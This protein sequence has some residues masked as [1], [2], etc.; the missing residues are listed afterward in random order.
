MSKHKRRI[1]LIQPQ[2][3]LKLIGTFLGMSALSLLLQFLLFTSRVSE[4]AGTLPQDG[5]LLMSSLQKTT[6]QI[7]L[8]SFGMLLP[9][10]FLVGVLV[11]FRWA[12]PLYR[13][14][15]HLMRIANGERPGDVRIR[16]GDE[17]QDFCE[18]LNRAVRDLQENPAGNTT[19]DEDESIQRAA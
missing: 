9:L 2:L 6:W 10:T 15:V 7:F 17:L 1:K 12:G 11:T 14:K 8:V 18:I 13:F 4:M 3:Q 19:E 5:I 16:K